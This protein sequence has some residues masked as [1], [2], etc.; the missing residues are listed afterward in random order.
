MK[1]TQ[2]IHHIINILLMIA[3]IVTNISNIHILPL[4]VVITLIF[5]VNTIL[6]IKKLQK[7]KKRSTVKKIVALFYWNEKNELLSHLIKLMHKTSNKL[8]LLNKNL[9]FTI[10]HVSELA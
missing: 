9:Y 1:Q 6:L 3:L 4:T 5:I 8:V 2:Y 10:Y 7:H